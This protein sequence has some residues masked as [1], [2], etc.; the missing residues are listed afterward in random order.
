MRVFLSLQGKQKYP[1]VVEVGSD[2]GRKF[3]PRLKE[4]DQC[5]VFLLLG[6]L[7]CVCANSQGT[8]SDT[9]ETNDLEIDPLIDICPS[10]DGHPGFY[11]NPS[12]LDDSASEHILATFS[13]LLQ[14]PQTAKRKQARVAAMTALKRFLSHAANAEYTDVTQSVYGQWCLQAL[15]ASARNMRIAAGFA[16]HEA[17]SVKS[18]LTVPRRA[19]SVFLRSQ[20]GHVILQSN[21]RVILESLRALS[22]DAD[23]KLQETCIL[24]WG[25]VAR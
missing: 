7:A 2:N 23:T 11:F 25:Q 18:R 12:L 22:A 8:W 19:M 3:Y 14:L 15:R 9:G 16:Y 24:A 17:A 5:L 20:V 4:S 10:C 1:F 13:G 6:Q 21:R